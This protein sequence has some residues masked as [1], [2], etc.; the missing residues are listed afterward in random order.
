M[1]R[2]LMRIKI[3]VI[4]SERSESKDLSANGINR[5]YRI[6]RCFA[7][8]A[9]L[10]RNYAYGSAQDDIIWGGLFFAQDDIYF[11]CG[12]RNAKLRLSLI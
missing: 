7:T 8:F 3:Y 1:M 9:V 12:M 11:E 10:W 2:F 6:L 4:L 5:I